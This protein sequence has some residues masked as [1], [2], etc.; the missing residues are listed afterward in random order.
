MFVE[1]TYFISNICYDC[2]VDKYPPYYA[3]RFTV[4][5]CINKEPELAEYFNEYVSVLSLEYLSFWLSYW[6][7]IIS[8]HM[9]YQLIYTIN[10]S[11][12]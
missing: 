3:K 10:L 4:Y 6:A 11:Y 5:K 2:I 8:I 7:A 9:Y 12:K 1:K